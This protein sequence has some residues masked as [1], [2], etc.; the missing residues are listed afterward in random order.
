MTSPRCAVWVISLESARER[1]EAFGN[2]A[3]KTSL[4]WQFVKAYTE[5]PQPLVYDESRV[6]RRF[7]RPLSPG[8]LGVYASHYK[9]WEAFLKSDL[10]QIL[11]LEDDVLV[12]WPLVERLARVNLAEQHVDFLRMFA[13][14]PIAGRV[15]MYRF[16]SPHS[17]LLRLQGL[18]LGLQAYFLTRHAAQVLLATGVEILEPIDWVTARYWKY[19]LP[20][21]CLF[22]FP[23]LERYVPSTIGASREEAAN[24][25]R[26][27][28]IERLIRRIWQ[29]LERAYVDHWV[30]PKAPFGPTHDVGPSL[31]DRVDPSGG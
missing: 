19:R 27:A 16:C 23:I 20:N 29:R 28:E 25:S 14:H 5:V 26:R 21:Y 8:E 30:F 4:Q 2:Q 17:H 11:L 12:D 9:A 18:T 22:P 31:V 3:Q 7:G 1:R 10:D 13:T 24:S 6:T 15:S